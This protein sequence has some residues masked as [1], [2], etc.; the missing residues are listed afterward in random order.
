MLQ[1]TV[2]NVK[3]VFSRL[4][5]ISTRISLGFISRGSAETDIGWGKKNYTAI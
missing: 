1:I 3:Y 5:H 4:L 2:N